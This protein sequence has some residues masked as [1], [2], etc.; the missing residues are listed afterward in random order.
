MSNAYIAP[1]RKIQGQTIGTD[2]MPT[3]INYYFKEK[4]SF[5]DFGGNRG[6]A[7]YFECHPLTE[8][9][10]TVVDVVKEALELGKQ[11]F[12]TASF[13]HYNKFNLLYNRGGNVDE[14]LP[15]ITTHDFSFSFDYFLSVDFT[16]MLTVVKWLWKHT[17]KQCVF[18]VFDKN[19][20][21]MLLEFYDALSNKEGT[22]FKNKTVEFYQWHKNNY[23]ICYLKDNCF[24]FF[25]QNSIDLNSVTDSQSGNI[26]KSFIAA[27]NLEWL[28]Q[29][30]ETE[31]GCS[32]RIDKLN[33]VNQKMS[34]V[35]L[36]R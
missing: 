31:L 34:T 5:I 8:N 22:V 3:T 16:E 17:K 27:Y 15:T 35:I 4:G 19:H 20:T 32:V 26:A 13:I 2:S 14:P 24:E 7:L 29:A 30:L 36:T 1:R 9:T 18:S 23:N 10:Y 21:F 25:D 28:K 33:P 11:E 12:P 6:N